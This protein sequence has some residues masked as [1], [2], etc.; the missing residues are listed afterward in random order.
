MRYKQHLIS[1]ISEDTS[2]C[3]GPMGCWVDV[4]K[5]CMEGRQ[6]AA[7]PGSQEPSS[8]PSSVTKQH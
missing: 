4:Y 8:V 6:H 5:C 2:G 7:Q 3:E 1:D